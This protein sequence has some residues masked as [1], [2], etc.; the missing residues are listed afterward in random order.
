MAGC[1]HVENTKVC[2]SFA[3]IY[4]YSGDERWRRTTMVI[5]IYVRANHWVILFIT[6][7][8]DGQYCVLVCNV[9]SWKD[10]TILLHVP[11]SVEWV[12]NVYLFIYGLTIAAADTYIA[13]RPRNRFDP[14]SRRTQSTQNYREHTHAH[15]HTDTRTSTHQPHTLMGKLKSF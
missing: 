6:R 5:D 8:S 4:K 9:H 7:W 15:I 14:K 12:S 3:N 11:N 1:K 10:G 13:C 2:A